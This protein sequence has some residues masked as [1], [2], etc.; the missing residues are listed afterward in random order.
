MRR[1]VGG[2][3]A[4]VL[5]VLALSEMGWRPSASWAQPP[6][7]AP[8]NVGAAG[9]LIALGTDTAEGRQQVT[10]IDSRAFVMTV[11]HV[12]KATGAIALKSVR[13]I[14]ADLMMDE[15][16][17]DNPLPKEIRAILKQRQ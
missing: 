8:G 14:Q 12:D 2:V 16:N 7:A 9:S 4:G 10:V 15:Y 1:A 3:V 17:T 5:I 6:T 13:N 11:Y